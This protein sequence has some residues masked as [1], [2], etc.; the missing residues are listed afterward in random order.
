MIYCVVK[1][2]LNGFKEKETFYSEKGRQFP[3]NS[4]SFFLFL[5]SNYDIF[6]SGYGLLQCSGSTFL[7]L[8]RREICRGMTVMETILSY[9]KLVKMDVGK[10]FFL[11]VF[12]TPFYVCFQTLNRN[13][14]L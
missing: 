1:I 6:S 8:F 13:A 10:S 5:F 4:I 3:D 11:S 2:I 12:Q 7:K 14:F 9:F